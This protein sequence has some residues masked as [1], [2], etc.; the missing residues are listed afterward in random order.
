MAEPDALCDDLSRDDGLAVE[1]LALTFDDVAFH[2]RT[3]A[4]VER[5]NAQLRKRAVGF[6]AEGI[7]TVAV[8]G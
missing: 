6:N 4:F 2:D 5:R 8:L 1:A 7:R 3:V